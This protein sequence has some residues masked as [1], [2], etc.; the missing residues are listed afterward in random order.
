MKSKDFEAS[1]GKK[2]PHVLEKFVFM[3]WGRNQS[4][5]F[6]EIEVLSTEF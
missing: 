5:V 2:S 4:Q 6:D 1:R 3:V